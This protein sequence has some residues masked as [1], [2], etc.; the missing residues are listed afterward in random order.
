MCSSC[1]IPLSCEYVAYVFKI[2]KILLPNKLEEA[3]GVNCGLRNMIDHLPMSVEVG[4]YG[5]TGPI[6]NPKKKHQE[7]TKK[8]SYSE[9]VIAS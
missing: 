6:M 2:L 8:A 4:P 1:E 7:T 3:S 5:V 9:S